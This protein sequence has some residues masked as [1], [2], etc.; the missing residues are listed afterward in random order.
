M[1][2]FWCLRHWKEVI[3]LFY[4]ARNLCRQNNVG[5]R[6]EVLGAGASRMRTFIRIQN[7]GVALCFVAYNVIPLKFLLF[8]NVWVPLTTMEI[9]YCD[10]ST[11]SGFIAASIIQGILAILTITA[12]VAF[13]IMFII[14][15]LQFPSRF[16][17]R[18]F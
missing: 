5:C 14:W 7:G 11:L 17:C 4:F 8:D 3:A 9:V 6:A 18:G 12:L 2:L 16:A 10:Q 1:K 13:G 15:W